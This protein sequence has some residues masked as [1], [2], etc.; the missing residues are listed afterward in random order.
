MP[1]E[2]L[3]LS[4]HIRAGDGVLRG[5]TAAEP[6]AL[7]RLL[8]AQ[9][10]SI[11]PISA[12]IGATWSDIAHPDHADTIHFISYCATAGNR[13]L[14]CIDGLVA[15]NSALEVDLAGHVNSEF[16]GTACVGAVGGAPDFLRGAMRARRGKS[17]V[18]L[19]ATAGRAD[20]TTSRI[21]ARLS[22]PVS[23]P[24]RDVGF[25]V[26]EYGIANLRH[27]SARERA[28]R[29]IAVAAP[30]FREALSRELPS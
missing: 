10:H 27:Q 19:P 9:R 6:V 8:V 21:V 28:R 15:I 22:G 4:S 5:Q 16:A 29:L 17:I 25:V 7:T 18:A 23:T 2:S 3:D 20:R 24:G 12:F 14:A 1:L 13:A 30:E 26:T 11:G